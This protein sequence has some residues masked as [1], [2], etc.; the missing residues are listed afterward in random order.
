MGNASAT[1]YGLKGLPG[2]YVGGPEGGDSSGGM[3]QHQRGAARLLKRAGN[4]NLVSGLGTGTTGQGIAGL[5]GISLDGVRPGQV[6]QLAQAAQNL[7]GPERELALA[8]RVSEDGI[9]A[10]AV[11]ADRAPPQVGHLRNGLPLSRLPRWAGPWTARRGGRSMPC[12]SPRRASGAGRSSPTPARPA[13]AGCWAPPTCCCPPEISPASRPKRR[14]RTACACWCS[15][16]PTQPTSARPAAPARTG[17][18]WRRP[19]CWCCGSGCAPRR[20]APWTTSPS[21]ASSSR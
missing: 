2:I 19:R 5:P 10:E 4:P 21:R 8:G 20:P 15:A 11:P 13:A 3:Q 17:R 7:N 6:P 14:P 18:R 9:P 12:R 1:S 16:G